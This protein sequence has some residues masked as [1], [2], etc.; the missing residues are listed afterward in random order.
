M[1]P[2]IIRSFVSGGIVLACLSL[3]SSVA[4]AWSDPGHQITAVTALGLLTPG[5]T[6]KLHGLLNEDSA[7]HGKTVAEQVKAAAIWP[8]TVKHVPNIPSTV[9]AEF[10]ITTTDKTGPLHFA[11]MK[12]AT[13]NKTVDCPDHCEVDAIA[14]CIRQLKD[15][16]VATK[17]KLEAVKFLI[18][19]VGDAHQPLH[20]GFHSDGGG[21]AI[22]VSGSF[23][24]TDLHHVWD[25]VIVDRA[26][27]S[28]ED[29]SKTRVL[30]LVNAHKAAYQSELRVEKWAEESHAIAVASAYK[31]NHGKKVI[32]GAQLEDA[33]LTNNQPI[34]DERLAMGGARLAAIL[35]SIFGH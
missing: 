30:P 7:L 3:T 20:S 19:L 5:A 2:S 22:K 24:H 34:V 15:S 17:T 28:V 11:D 18:H 29:Y 10:G 35:E 32:T 26:G 8:D 23:P 9:F 31:D 16:G 6:A 12:G 33:Y 1:K 25:A 27:L 14:L 4:R 21:N 13:F